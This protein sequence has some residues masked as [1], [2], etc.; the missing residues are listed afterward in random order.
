MQLTTIEANPAS[1]LEVYRRAAG[2]TR[3]QLGHLASVSAE[4]VARLER[5]ENRP[6]KSTAIVLAAVLGVEVEQLFP[7]ER[8]DG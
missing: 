1:P 7:L 4:T 5:R 2:L 3:P 8:G 6:H